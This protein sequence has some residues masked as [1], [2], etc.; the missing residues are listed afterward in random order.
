MKENIQERAIPAAI[1]FIAPKD[2][3][4]HI[5]NHTSIILRMMP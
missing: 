1:S 3:S 2:I 5:Y 4:E